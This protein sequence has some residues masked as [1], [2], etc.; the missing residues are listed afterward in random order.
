MPMDKNVSA[1]L[2]DIVA[3]TTRKLD[4]VKCLLADYVKRDLFAGQALPNI[5]DRRFFPTNDMIKGHIG[6]IVN[7]IS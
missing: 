6:H 3:K 4:V 1:K 5:C 2:K 7:T